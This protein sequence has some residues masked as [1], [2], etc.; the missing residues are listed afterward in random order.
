MALEWAIGQLESHSADRLNITS[1]LRQIDD[2]N[3][4]ARDM[5]R[6]VWVAMGSSTQSAALMEIALD[7]R[8]EEGLAELMRIN[9]EL[10]AKASAIIVAMRQ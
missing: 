3:R 9:E 5:A 8:M 10:T 6:R 4:S 2:A 1:H 7:T